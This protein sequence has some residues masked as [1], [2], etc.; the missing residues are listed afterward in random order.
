[1]RTLPGIS[2]EV[3]T[4][5]AQ[6]VGAGGGG[7]LVL[8]KPWPSMLRGIWGDEER[9]R[10]TYWSRFEE[11]G[12]YFAGD[13][14]KYDDDGA[15]W[16]LG[17][18][19][20]VM[21]VSGHRISTTEVESALVSHPTVAEA[22]VVGAS[23]EQT[24]QGIVAFVILRGN[25]AKDEA[26][27]EEAIKALRDHV[28]K[29]I[30]PIAKPRQIMVVEELPKTRSGKIMRRLLRDVA[31]HR[32][33]GD[34]TTLADSSVMDLI[35]AGM[36]RRIL[37]GLTDPA[38]GTGP[39]RASCTW[40]FSRASGPGGQGVNTTDSRVEL[41]FDVARS[42]T[43]PEHLRARAQGRL[44]GR[45][46][47]GVL[48]VVASEHRSQLR[49]REAA[50][51]RLAEMLRTALAP[52][53]PTA[54]A[55]PG[56]PRG[57]AGA[58][59]TRRP[60]AVRSSACAAA[61]RVAS[62]GRGNARVGTVRARLAGHRAVPVEGCPRKIERTAGGSAVASPT[63]RGGAEAVPPVL[64]SIPLSPEPVT[65]STEQSIGGLVKEVT[66]HV[67]TLVRAEV[68]LAKA[69]VTA[70]V[71][72]G[73]QGSIFFI[74]AAVIVL[75]SLFFLF[76]TVAELLAMW[77]PRWAAFAITFG[78]MVLAAALFGLLGYL[79]VRKIRKPER[80]ISSLKESAQVLSHRG[81]PE[82]PPS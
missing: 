52:D 60:A 61:R 77:L 40:R 12:Y 67:S 14:A 50:R 43:L 31:E 48:T 26:K 66:A 39:R 71:K 29:E 9:Y 82:A 63:S 53:P 18:V 42:P 73:V 8:D 78:I 35:S 3:V 13:G 44:E 69:E 4:E 15:I 17:R 1:M 25:A 27:G 38:Q 33:V 81:H 65:R 51:E 59:S 55:R 57:P 49:N 22:A 10:E 54:A 41:S 11:Q 37:G 23:D 68:E 24:G 74:V 20:D 28:S 36:T 19:D 72:K 34:V 5:E 79:R 46:V 7:Y 16:L 2:A 80:T 58:G 32:E 75:F 56:R 76:F 21:N 47:D 70:E 45:L 64:P 62:R 30:G 6:P